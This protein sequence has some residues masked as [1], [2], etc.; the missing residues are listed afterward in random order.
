M[1]KLRI[2]LP[3]VQVRSAADRAPQSRK[4]GGVDWE[5]KVSSDKGEKSD[6]GYGSER[7]AEGMGRDSVRPRGVVVWPRPVSPRLV[8]RPPLPLCLGC[9]AVA[10]HASALPLPCTVKPCSRF[11][12]SFSTLRSS[13]AC[14]R[15]GPADRALTDQTDKTGHYGPGQTAVPRCPEP[16]ASRTAEMLSGAA[17]C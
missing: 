17:S 14:R 6:K 2:G 4:R 3:A 16:T 13:A 5:Q 15:P 9:S 11:A 1:G 10:I 8:P 12:A 7:Y